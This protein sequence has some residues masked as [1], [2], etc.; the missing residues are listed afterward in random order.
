MNKLVK[1]IALGAVAAMVTLSVVGAPTAEAGHRRH[2]GNGFHHGHHKTFF[3]VKRN[4]GYCATYGWFWVG[5]V[6]KWGCLN[7]G[8]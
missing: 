3:V 5:G 7:Y 4:T 6:K 8:Y 1:K 2:F